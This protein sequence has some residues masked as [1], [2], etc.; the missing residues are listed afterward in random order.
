MKICRTLI[1]I[2]PG[3][4]SEHGINTLCNLASIHLANTK[5]QRAEDEMNE[6]LS[7]LM[8][9]NSI[10]ENL[11][12]FMV[13]ILRDLFLLHMKIDDIIEA[14]KNLNAILNIYYSLHE[15][16][17]SAYDD[18]IGYTY[19]LLALSQN[20]SNRNNEAK[21]SCEKAIEI[22]KSI[23][24]KKESELINQYLQ[25]AQELLVDI[26]KILS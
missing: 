9:F 3:Q 17:P 18:H 23:L 15:K 14:E 26:C 11:Q 22:F 1:K 10:P 20:Q 5:V 24:V 13:S 19:L 12:L 6:A 25:K 4:Y 7:I 2:N 8:A 21:I 16:K